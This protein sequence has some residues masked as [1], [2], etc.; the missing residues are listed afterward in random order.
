MKAPGARLDAARLGCLA[1]GLLWLAGCGGGPRL[2]E[3]EAPVVLSG[4][5]K[6]EPQIA[7]SRSRSGRIETWTVDGEALNRLEFVKGA[8][9]G[10]ALVV[11]DSDLPENEGGEL[12]TFDWDMTGLEVHDLYV[13]SL[14]Q[15]GY[16]R[17]ATRDVEPWQVGPRPGFRFAFSHVAEDGIER[18]GLAVGFF[19]DGELWLITYTAPTVHYFRKFKPQVE[20]L[21]SS[22]TLL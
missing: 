12:P 4:T 17:I 21:L 2:I 6:V 3:A 9:S 13:A 16:S 19:D 18:D 20:A 11:S 14:S 8:S 5:L 22:M 7:W 15:L 10:D 1:A